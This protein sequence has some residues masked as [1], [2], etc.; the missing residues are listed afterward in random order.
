[1]RIK[2]LPNPNEYRIVAENLVSHMKNLV[3]KK[4]LKILKFIGVTK[5]LGNIVGRL[6]F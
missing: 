3:G 1:M 5:N 4:F 2:N 6:N